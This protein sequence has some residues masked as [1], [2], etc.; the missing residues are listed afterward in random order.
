M[1]PVG[2]VWLGVPWLP[3]LLVGLII[4]LL[5]TALLAPDRVRPRESGGVEAER[6]AE[7]EAIASV[8][9]F[10]W[11]LFCGLLIAILIG[12]LV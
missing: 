11:V 8:D 3:Y 7:T 12:Y 2:P 1:T 5:L 10:M 4:A 9:A 6:R